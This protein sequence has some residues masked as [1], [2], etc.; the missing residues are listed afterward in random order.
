MLLPCPNEDAAI[1]GFMKKF[2]EKTANDWA[3]RSHFKAADGKYTLVLTEDG[4]AT[5]SGGNDVPLGKLSKPQIE[6]G[7][8]VLERIEEAINA[9]AKGTLAALSSEFYSLIPHN[10]GRQRPEAITALPKLFEKVEM[11]KFYLRM[12]FEDL[13]TKD[14]HAAPISGLMDLPLPSSL[15]EAAKGLCSAAEVKKCVSKGLALFTKRAGDPVKPMDKELYASIM[16]YTGNA[17]YRDLNQALRDQDRARVGKYFT[18]LRLF[19][20]AMGRLPEQARQL[21]R[22]VGADLYDQY[23]VG[24]VITWWGVSS[25][26]SDLDVAKGFMNG[27]G[28]KKTLLTVHAKRAC[29]ISTITFYSHEKENLLA[30]GTQL[31]VLQSSKK[32]DV[33]EITL[34]E[35]GRCVG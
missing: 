26:T 18:F 33:T 2:K 14:E 9:D 25:C 32:G 21:W 27:C 10:F 13:D 24:S 22:G 23:A 11:L 17:I 8:A 7:Q 4:E 20:E 35:V 29:D 12:G 28:G 1:K 6:K 30:P 34:E 19:L 3:N 31:K 15:A 5:G 16:L